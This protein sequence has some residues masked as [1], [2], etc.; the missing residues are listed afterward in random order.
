MTDVPVVDRRLLVPSSAGRSRLRRFGVAWRNRSERRISAV[1]LLTHQAG[2]YTFRYLAG[3][4]DVPGFRPLLGFPQ[5]DQ[6]YTSARLFPF[7]AQRIMDPRRPDYL[8][9]LQALDLPPDA[10]RLDVLGRSG[11]Q[12]KAD[13]V[14]VVE[15]P[16]TLEG[17]RTECTFLAQGVRHGVSPDDAAAFSS[18]RVGVELTLTPQPDN[19]VNRRALLITAH[20]GAALGWAPD[21]LLD[22]LHTVRRSGP[23]RLEVRRINGPEIPPHLRLVVRLSGSVPSGYRAFDDDSP[24]RD[25]PPR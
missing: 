7:F 15:E 9:Y 2:T 24:W 20:D 10:S 5:I 4:A 11:G 22:Y 18:L 1:G 25:L 13:R 16:E 23:H 17:G 21:L 12:R 3:A 19:P 14:Q 6:T 8:R